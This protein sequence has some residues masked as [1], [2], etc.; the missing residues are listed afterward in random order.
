VILLVG[1]GLMVRGF[2]TLLNNGEKLEPATL[3]TMRLAITSN[4][5]REPHQIE[6]FYRQVLEHITPFPGVKIIRAGVTSPLKA[7]R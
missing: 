1:A 4:K 3:L 5:Y 2:H 6:A 7:G